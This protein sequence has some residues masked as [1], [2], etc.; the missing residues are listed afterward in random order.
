M[1]CPE[2]TWA[3]TVGV[4]ALT[5]LFFLAHILLLLLFVTACSPACQAMRIWLTAC[6]LVLPCC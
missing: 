1:H 2:S 4:A 5:C 6:L 3:A